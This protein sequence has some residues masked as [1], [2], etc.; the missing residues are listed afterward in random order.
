MDNFCEM[1]QVKSLQDSKASSTLTVDHQTISYH[2]NADSSWLEHLTKR[3][4][5]ESDRT[6]SD[7][8][9]VPCKKLPESP[10]IDG[11]RPPMVLDSKGKNLGD[12][13]SGEEKWGLE[14]EQKGS[15]AGQG[16]QGMSSQGDSPQ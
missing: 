9:L 13:G 15:V 8:V 4:Q 14:R 12:H 10:R 16:D 2:L 7:R 5:F 11:I 3:H 1:N 6:A